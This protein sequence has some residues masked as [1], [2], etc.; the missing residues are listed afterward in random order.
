MV[1]FVPDKSVG[2]TTEHSNDC[3]AAETEVSPKTCDRFASPSCMRR[4][5]PVTSRSSLSRTRVGL[6]SIEHCCLPARL[7]SRVRSSLISMPSSF[8]LRRLPSSESVISVIL[9]LVLSPPCRLLLLLLAS[10]RITFMLGGAVNVSLKLGATFSSS[11]MI[12]SQLVED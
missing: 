11:T 10:S 7:P 8:S 4:N 9:W 3:A 1:E 5:F 12:A 6:R 2:R